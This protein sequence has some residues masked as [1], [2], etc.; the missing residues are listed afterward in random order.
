M[1]MAGPDG[2][3]RIHRFHA[4][5]RERRR[6]GRGDLLLYGASPGHEP[7]GAGQPAASRR[8]AAAFP[9]R[10]AHPAGRIA[11]LR[12]DSDHAAADGG[13]ADAARRL[14]ARL[15]DEEAADRVWT[16]ETAVPRVHLL[17]QR[18]LRADGH[19]LRR[20]I[21]PLERIRSHAMAIR[22][23]AGSVGEFYLCP[24]SCAPTKSGPR[25]TNPL[26]TARA[27]AW[28]GFACGPRGV[29]PARVGDRDGHGGDDQRRKTM[30]S[31]GG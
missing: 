17:R 6:S 11:A 20:R 21:Q 10:S 3:L 23:H 1:G 18:T 7:R 28:C 12:A 5:A 15:P 27:R 9:W 19:Q 22:P 2:F 24:R 13:E 14:C 16:E 4:R 8:H 30:R 29:P 25:R 31:C 26:Q